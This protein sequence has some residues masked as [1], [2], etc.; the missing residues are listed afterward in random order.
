MSDIHR[1]VF[2]RFQS[3]VDR[4]ASLSEL[5]AELQDH[6]EGCP[7]C[8]LDFEIHQGLRAEA[9]LR[10]PRDLEPRRPAG[11]TLAAMEAELGGNRHRR[12]VYKSLSAAGWIILVILLVLGANWAIAN[13]RPQP[14]VT[15][16]PT[17][18]Q[19]F[20]PPVEAA[21]PTPVSG[22]ADLPKTPLEPVA[23][24]A[25][26]PGRGVWSPDSRWVFFD[27]VNAGDDPRS[28]RRFTTLN[29]LDAESGELCRQPQ[30][31][32]GV[33]GVENLVRWLPDN[34]LLFSSWWDLPPELQAS[35]QQPPEDPQ[36]FVSGTPGVY[37]LTPCEDELLSLNDHFSEDILGLPFT[38]SEGQY[39]LLRGESSYW[40]LDPET[41]NARPVESLIPALE[42]RVA[43]SPSGD[44]V[45][46][47]QPEPG[48]SVTR[49]R[50]SLLD[51]G[52]GEVTA[53]FELPS[54]GEVLMLDWLVDEALFVWD[55][56]PTGPLLVELS[57]EAPQVISVL[58]ELFGLD[59]PH[60]DEFSASSSV[61]DPAAGSYHIAFKVNTS[62]D[63]A[64]YLF[65]SESGEVEV[66]PLVGHTYLIYPDGDFE[67][68]FLAE[69]EPSYTDEFDLVWVDDPEKGITH[70]S[71]AGHTPRDY[72]ILWPRLAP[73]LPAIAFASS[74]GVSLVSIP[75]GQLLEFWE[76]QGLAASSP[77]TR[78]SPDGRYLTV[79]ASDNDA[80]P[81]DPGGA[82][83]LIPLD[84]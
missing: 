45:A 78:L 77:T 70:L 64:T 35:E 52:S 26:G 49:G 58:P 57:A 62:E 24:G 82:F 32:L 17:E 60:P 39:I 71:V 5:R 72:P 1:D 21:T 80:A 55:F 29:F 34:R 83:Y 18:Q 36:V 76:L 33:V 50:I 61:G 53:E 28:D 46:V 48:E 13:L 12:Q 42:D 22:G 63:K 51:A 15:A 7:D 65:H 2:E 8:R 23:L 40:L 10:W 30:T 56:S 73:N 59:L 27:L 11:V 19:Q 6:L 16:E 3:G 54:V 81:P 37:V 43:W 68:L 9:A 38:Q 41:L 47:Y 69:D 79:A 67:P 66:I 75:D 20:I 74:Q 84:Q 44:S 14:A 25:S 31:L 4:G